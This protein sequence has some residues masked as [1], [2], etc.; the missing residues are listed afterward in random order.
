MGEE[1][2]DELIQQARAGDARAQCSLGTM[3]EHGEG[4]PHNDV[5]AVKWYRLA[6]EQ[7]NAEAQ[8]CLGSMYFCNLGVDQDY[9]E[10]M[11]WYC[12]AAE[13]GHT[14]AQYYIG[15]AY[16]KGDGV[17]KDYAEAMKWYR[18]AA[19]RGYALAQ[20]ALGEVYNRCGRSWGVQQ[21]YAAAVKWY[22]LAAAQGHA[23][24][25]YALGEMYGEG[26]GVL[27]NDAAAVK[28]IQLAAKQEYYLAQQWIEHRDESWKIA[29]SWDACV[30]R[31]EQPAL[32]KKMIRDLV[33][34][35]PIFW[36]GTLS[37]GVILPGF[38]G[39]LTACS[40]YLALFGFLFFMVSSK[41]EARPWMLFWSATLGQEF[42]VSSAWKGA[43]VGMMPFVIHAIAFV[44]YLIAIII[45]FILANDD[46][47]DMH[48]SL[49]PG[50][51]A[52]KTAVV[53]RNL[54]T[55][56]GVW[57]LILMGRAFFTSFMFFFIGIC[58]AVSAIVYAARACKMERELRSW[59]GANGLWDSSGD[60]YFSS[61]VRETCSSILRDRRLMKL[62]GKVAACILLSFVVFSWGRFDKVISGWGDERKMFEQYPNQS[63]KAENLARECPL[64]VVTCR[65]P[66]R[67]S[68]DENSCCLASSCHGMRR[69]MG[70][71][72][73]WE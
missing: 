8:C 29:G 71:Y 36:G 40:F 70:D 30:F 68:K 44:S 16:S 43:H 33:K 66:S 61:H 26:H 15:M 46:A 19:E 22:R 56:T 34:G 65:D 6:A 52:Q 73:S 54:S 60:D 63:V 23:P 4:V 51:I 67:R 11:K 72:F 28:W 39:E 49:R 47:S 69:G 35:F 20:Y 57:L 53:T 55:C 45:A 2:L 13:Q 5:E 17:S 24:A 50:V 7:G 18:L 37:L 21:D 25:Q 32:R 27:K 31:H 3:C 48:S 62:H 58:F 9:A 12:L 64:V 1:K 42:Y 14:R 59:L 10:A 38:W 41:K